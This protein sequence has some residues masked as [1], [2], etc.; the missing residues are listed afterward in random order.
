MADA[1]FSLGAPAAERD[2]S[3][4]DCFV[5]SDIYESLIA[6]RC[7]VLIGN[8]GAG[9][10]A[11]FEI[12]ADHC[13]HQNDAVVSISPDD[14]SYEMLGEALRSEIDGSWAKQGSYTASWKYVLLVT[15]MKEARDRFP[16]TKDPSYKIINNYLNINFKNDKLD[17]LEHLVS[18]MKRF[19]SLKVGQGE[20]G[21]QT[22][23]LRSL[24]RLEEVND[25]IEHL[26]HL[27]SHR[28][29]VILIDE[30][31]RGWDA[32]EDARLFVAGLFQAAMTANQVSPN[33]RVLISLRRELFDNIPE[34]YD[35]AQ[36]VRD[37]IRYV[38]WSE[39]GLKEVA[40][41]R[42]N[43][44]LFPNE[45]IG[46]EEAWER[47]FSETLTYR[48]TKSFNYMVDRT[49]YRPREIIQFCN[50]CIVSRG[51]GSEL[52][53]YDVITDAESRYSRDRFSDIC[54][55]YKFQYPKLSLVLES[56][57]GR[58]Y[59]FTR[60]ELSLFCTE[61]LI[62]LNERI[63]WLQ[64]LEEE[65]LI[66]VLWEVGFLKALAKGGQKAIARSGSRWVGNY[67]QPT[68][69]LENIESFQVHPMFRTCL[70]MKEK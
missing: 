35:D 3:L 63:D 24:Y 4:R 17:I 40:G 53:D 45:E 64:H 25:K 33:F 1:S 68:L 42:I 22:K 7:H 30:L 16:E 48:K 32:S 18:Y 49:L 38:E 8:R 62:D 43:H 29:V 31:D 36:K 47:I 5:Q 66:D 27:L 50:E 41:R 54:S 52:I 44:N 23:Q 65:D 10:S 2:A 26:R 15:A 70:G 59:S 11:L 55:E 9:K 60:E 6:D 67:Q 51:S 13:K 69:N 39:D 46:A 28:R 20:V 14:Y 58:V 56:F 37:L 61:I 12:F 34:I 57:R 19:E 21:L